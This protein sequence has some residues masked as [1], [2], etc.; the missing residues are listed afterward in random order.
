MIQPLL[1][2]GLI[3]GLALPVYLQQALVNDGDSAVDSG[4][5]DISLDGNNDDWNTASEDEGDCDEI[6]NDLRGE[7]RDATIRSV[8]HFSVVLV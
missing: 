1:L 4:A 8:T 3:H 5:F 2:H 7:H 6:I